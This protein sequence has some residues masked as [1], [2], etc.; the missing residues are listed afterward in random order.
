LS[1]YLLYPDARVAAN[2]YTGT[3]LAISLAFHALWRYASTRLLSADATVAKR[4]EAAQIT[5]QYRFGPVLYFGAFGV[6]FV[7]EGWS[8][9]LCLFLALFFAFRG[10]P[11]RGGRPHRWRS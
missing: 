6:S 8:V 10:R 5:R 2:L 11:G 4:E 9:A 7:S 3:F 1:E